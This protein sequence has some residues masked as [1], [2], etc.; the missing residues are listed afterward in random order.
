M[1]VTT[2][3]AESPAALF[4]DG[5]SLQRVLINLINNA[6]DASAGNGRINIKTLVSPGSSGKAPEIIIEVADNGAGIPAE[7][8]PKIFD[9]FVTTK[10]AG[11]GTGLGLAICQEIIKAHGG[12]INVASEVG[13]GTTVQILLPTDANTGESV[14]EE[15]A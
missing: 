14:T 6:V 9:L 2:A 11:K 13:Q 3:L 8:L 7:I 10:P 4:G 15:I 12:N 5:V 1:V